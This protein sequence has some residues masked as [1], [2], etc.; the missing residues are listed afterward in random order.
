MADLFFDQPSRQLHLTGVT[1][2]N[3]KTTISTLVVS[4]VYSFWLQMRLDLDSGK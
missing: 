3:G 1:G 2:T 4:V